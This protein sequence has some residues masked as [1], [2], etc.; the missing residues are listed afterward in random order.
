MNASAAE[1]EFHGDMILSKCIKHGFEFAKN[2]L[3]F[4]TCTLQVFSFF[5][6][7]MTFW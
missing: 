2:L 3:H 7:V 1:T 4:I 6:Y 5:C